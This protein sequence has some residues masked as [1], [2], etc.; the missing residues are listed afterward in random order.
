LSL[1]SEL[2]EVDRLASL[3]D[4]PRVVSRGICST[5]CIMLVTTSLVTA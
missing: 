1:S 2:V 4:A 3:V 5:C